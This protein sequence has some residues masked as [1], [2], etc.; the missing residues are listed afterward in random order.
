MADSCA[1]QIAHSFTEN[2]HKK[3]SR[4]TFTNE[5]AKLSTTAAV[6]LIITNR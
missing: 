1:K 2:G 3:K 5:S 4:L 6:R